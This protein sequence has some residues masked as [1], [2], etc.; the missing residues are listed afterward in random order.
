VHHESGAGKKAL[1]IPRRAVDRPQ[2]NRRQ[3]QNCRSTATSLE[4]VSRGETEALRALQP[5]S[6]NLDGEHHQ[7]TAAIGMPS[8]RWPCAILEVVRGTEGQ[9]AYASIQNISGLPQGLAGLPMAS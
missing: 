6:N 3:R 8:S 7:P 2:D 9:A 5:G 1:P 4:G